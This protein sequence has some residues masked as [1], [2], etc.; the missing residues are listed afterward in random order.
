[1]TPGPSPSRGGPQRV[2][3]PASAV[4]LGTVV[5]VASLWLHRVRARSFEDFYSIYGGRLGIPDSI[6]PNAALS[7]LPGWF[8]PV[9]AAGQVLFAYLAWRLAYIARLRPDLAAG[10]ELFA[11]K[12][13]TCALGLVLWTLGTVVL[14]PGE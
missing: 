8:F 6:P 1:M 3:W 9:S 7:G 14:F 4:S 11:F 10:D 13:T 12:S 5:L 2:G